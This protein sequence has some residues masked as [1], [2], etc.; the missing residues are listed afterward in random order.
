MRAVRL[1][2]IEKIHVRSVPEREPGSGEVVVRVRVCGVCGT[3]RHILRGEYPAKL[4]VTLGHEF[5]G[6]VAAAGPDVSL[7]AG[8]PV[9]V[10]PNISCG[11]CRE[12][13]CGDV[14]L[15]RNRVALGVDVDGGLAQYAVVPASQLYPIPPDMSMAH[16]A[17]CEPLACCLHGLDMAGIEPGMS[18]AVL[19]GGVIGQLMVQLA[20][21]A[22]ANTVVLATRQASRRALAESLGATATTNPDSADT[23]AVISGSQ[24]IAPGGVDVVLECAG[25]VTTFEQAVHLARRG[26]TI[27]IFGVAPQEAVAAISP[28][29]VFSRE[30]RIFG[31]YLN[32]LTHGR[33]VELAAAG[34]LSLDPLIT[35]RV[36]LSGVPGLLAAP[37][38][39]GEVKAMMVSQ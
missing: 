38:A 28:F 31:S 25:T 33:A 20:R 8:L 3:D 36:S 13:R 11:R 10:N 4:P 2:A 22:G 17:L 30:L 26:G 23:V 32:P 29:D 16:G 34:S 7:Q 12:C 35:H 19:G 39:P 27:L 37:P 18:V 1:E 5:A 14:A 15:C 9:A 24:G 6:T 21:L